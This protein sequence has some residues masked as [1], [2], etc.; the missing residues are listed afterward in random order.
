M[1]D[2]TEFQN[3]TRR[4]EPAA[5]RAAVIEAKRGEA[6]GRLKI[7]SALC[8]VAFACPDATNRVYDI[9]ANAWLGSGDCA[10]APDDL[11]EAPL[12]D[13]FWEAYW[14]VVD[15]AE[16]GYDATSIT[17]AVASLSAAVHSSMEQIAE[18]SASNH[19]GAAAALSRPVPGRTDLEALGACAE[20]S[21]GRTLYTMVVDNGYDLEVLDRDAIMLNQLPPALCYL[22]TRIL[23]MHD[24][25]H[26]V[27]GYETS[28][29]HEIAISSFQLAQFGHNYSA[30]FL[31]TV[32]MISHETQAVGFPILM[33]IITEAWQ[34]GRQAP[35][36]M[37][38]E[39]EQ[40]WH[41]TIPAIREEYAIPVYRS[42]CPADLMETVS[43]AP[44]WRRLGLGFKVAAWRRRFR[45]GGFLRAA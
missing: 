12:E 4:P 33:Q 17:V 26:L 8:W 22:N 42:A 9:L 3:S 31:A 36:F 25:W 21:L 32:A 2:R 16:Q 18:N 41:K 29:S 14:A 40:E 38:I 37:D 24:V 44:L 39:W 10:R 30:M 20:D 28:G 35:A 19:P 27:A 11:P 15:G 23:Q 5:L 43:G 13:G 1:T 6:S 34:H 45:K 7:T